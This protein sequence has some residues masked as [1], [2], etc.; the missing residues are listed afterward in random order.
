MRDHRFDG[1]HRSCETAER[2]FGRLL[3]L[4]R[5]MVILGAFVPPAASLL[6][7]EPPLGAEFT[8]N[9]YTTGSQNAASVAVGP[10]GRFV[11]V[12]M[13]VWAMRRTT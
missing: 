9:T 8:V 11:V 3:R 6:A 7:Q 5:V 12:W 2:L 10:D 4:L 13:S 1:P